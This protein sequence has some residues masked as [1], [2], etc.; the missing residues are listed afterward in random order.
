MT[1]VLRPPVPGRKYRVIGGAFENRLCR[2]EEIYGN[3]NHSP[4]LRVTL[5]NGWGLPVMDEVVIASR[6][7]GNGK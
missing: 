4:K 7:L 5:C 3:V 2:L 6:F 1:D